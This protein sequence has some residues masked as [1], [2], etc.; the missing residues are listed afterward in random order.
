M[1]P[2]LAG[3]YFGPLSVFDNSGLGIPG[4]AAEGYAIMNGL[5]GTPFDMRGFVGVGSIQGIP[6][7]ALDPIVDPVGNANSR[8][9]KEDQL[10]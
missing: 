4:T 1:L 9:V 5:N 7:P 8:E 6:G 2:F 3:L 10:V